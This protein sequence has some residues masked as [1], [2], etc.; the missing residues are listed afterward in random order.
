MSNNYLKQKGVK[1]LIASGVLVGFSVFAYMWLV[2]ALSGYDARHDLDA[3]SVRAPGVIVIVGLSIL[4]SVTALF[5]IRGW[6]K[7]AAVIFLITSVCV[8]GLT[9]FA[10]ALSV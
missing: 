5:K 2:S 9:V 4:L 3:V 6:L 1:W 10:Y 8:L 7:A